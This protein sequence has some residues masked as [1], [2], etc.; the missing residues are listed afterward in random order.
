MNDCGALNTDNRGNC[1]FSDLKA[2]EG[3]K[4]EINE[5]LLEFY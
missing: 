1:K 4:E 2:R 5:K 3:R